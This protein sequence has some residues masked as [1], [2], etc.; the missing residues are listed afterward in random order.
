MRRSRHE[1]NRQVSRISGRWTRRPDSRLRFIYEEAQNLVAVQ[2]QL[3]FVGEG[4]GAALSEHAE[5]NLLEQGMSIP[6][7]HN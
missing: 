1:H 3:N 2:R 5:T 6:D 4:R 7:E